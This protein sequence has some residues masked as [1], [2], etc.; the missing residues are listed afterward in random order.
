MKNFFLIIVFFKCLTS[1]AQY[2]N[3]EMEYEY[4]QEKTN[5]TG[6]LDGE[7]I[8]TS[9]DERV[10]YKHLYQNGE[11]LETTNYRFIIE[12]SRELVGKYKN[13]KPFDGYFV[14]TNEM[15]IP[16]VDYYEKGVFL[17]QYTCSLLDLISYEG[18]ELKIK[19]IKT[20]YLNAKPQSGLVH[21]EKTEV[22]GATLVASEYYADG[23]ITNV[24]FWVMAVH[25]AELFKLKFLSNGYQIYKESIPNVEDTVID[26]TFKSITIEFENPKKGNIH[27]EV[28]HKLICKYQF[29]Y[30][31]ISE[32]LKLLPGHMSY[33]FLSDNSILVEQNANIETNDKKYNEAYGSNAG[34]ISNIFM[35]MNSQPIPYFTSNKVNDY[36]RILKSDENFVANATLYIDGKGKP[37]S[38]FFIEKDTHTDTYKCIQ[39]QDYKII[40]EKNALTLVT[41]K[42]LLK[43]VTQ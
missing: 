27:Y 38:G 16:V 25:Y 5:A 35:M 34:L 4:D 22:D 24:D 9:Y 19:F 29:S 11:L 2:T 43:S 13:K 41:L 23:K 42:Q 31:D 26:N 10:A 8:H 3:M 14:F 33:F 39:Y 7:L 12:G 21:R 36:S 32:K 40:S 18:Q 15:E 28:E 1:Q 30:S 20:T 37:V 6:Q 17:A